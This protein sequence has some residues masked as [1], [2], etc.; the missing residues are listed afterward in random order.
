MEKESVHT[1]Y[2]VFPKRNV[3]PRYILQEL[4]S[5]TVRMSTLLFF[6]DGLTT[7][8][9]KVVSAENEVIGRIDS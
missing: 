3:L 1:E 8:I 6:N 9:A 7:Y 5:G 2:L 4:S